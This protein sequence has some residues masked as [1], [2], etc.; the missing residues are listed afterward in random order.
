MHEHAIAGRDAAEDT[1]PH[2]VWT[3]GAESETLQPKAHAGLTSTLL[4]GLLVA[5]L[6]GRQERG[7]E[8]QVDDDDR[9]GLGDEE[10]DAERE[11]GVRLCLG[12]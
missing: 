2:P 10:R 7:G 6:W 3:L 12:G 9:E 11:I 1:H 4:I 8:G 5:F